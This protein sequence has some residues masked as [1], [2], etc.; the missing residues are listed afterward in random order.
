MSCSY[1]LYHMQNKH[2]FNSKWTKKCMISVRMHRHWCYVLW[3]VVWNKSKTYFI[4]EKTRNSPSTWKHVLPKYNNNNNSTKPSFSKLWSLPRAKNVGGL[5]IS[6]RFRCLYFNKKK[7][8][9]TCAFRLFFF[10]TRNDLETG[11]RT[12]SAIRAFM[13]VYCSPP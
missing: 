7:K 2:Q 6:N 8:Y 9:S 11:V 4:K 12:L 3:Y 1:F 5:C 10:A 13:N